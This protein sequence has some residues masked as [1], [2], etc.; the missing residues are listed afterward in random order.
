MGTEKAARGGVPEGDA[1]K[2]VNGD[3]RPGCPPSLVLCPECL[4]ALDAKLH[5]LLGGPPR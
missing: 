4:V 2:C 3:L 1:M 5:A